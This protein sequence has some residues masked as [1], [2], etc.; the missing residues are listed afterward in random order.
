MRIRG[1]TLQWWKNYLSIK[2]ELT[3]CDHRFSFIHLSPDHRLFHGQKMTYE[4]CIACLK[5]TS[6]H[7]DWD[8]GEEWARRWEADHDW[9]KKEKI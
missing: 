7:S 9:W 1:R 8:R 3:T 2:L 4:T 6:R 5:V